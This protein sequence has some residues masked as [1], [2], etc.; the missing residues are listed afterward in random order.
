MDPN[1]TLARIIDA[2]TAGDLDELREACADL[3][4]WIERGGFWPYDPRRI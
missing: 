2:A 3:I 1:E 4:E